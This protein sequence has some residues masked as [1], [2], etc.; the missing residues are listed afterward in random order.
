MPDARL[1]SHG[2]KHSHRTE[3]VE[4]ARH[5]TGT[6]HRTEA[7]EGAGEDPLFIARRLL[8]FASEDI[9]NADPRALSVALDCMQATR[10]IGMPE[11]RII[12]GQA[13]TYLATAPKSNAAYLGI[14]TAIAAVRETGSLPVP[15]HI[16]NA[17]TQLMKSM[18]RGEGYRY[19]HDHGGW[20]PEHYLPEAL[21]GAAFY[22]PKEAG[23]E[24]HIAERL[25]Q[26]RTRRDAGDDEA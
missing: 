16:R 13:C 25:R 15:N 9:G 4:G 19:P 23:Y 24:R 6:P 20:V 8:I 11:A 2:H 21:R 14:N 7:A 22:S 26:W 3:V 18:G 1:G 10:M 17:P 5:P 12:M